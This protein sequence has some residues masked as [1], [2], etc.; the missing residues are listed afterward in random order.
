MAKTLQTGWGTAIRRI[1]QTSPW[2]WLWEFQLEANSTVHTRVRLTA[3]HAQ[4]T[5]NGKTYHPF[6]MHQGT[7]EET[8]EGDLP[9]TRVVLSNVGREFGN[10]FHT[11]AEADGLIG[12]IATSVLV[13]LADLTQFWEYDWEVNDALVGDHSI[14]LSLQMPNFMLR[15][16]PEDRFSPRLCR[17]QF[18]Q[19]TI[20]RP[21]P[22]GYPITAQAA[23]QD[24]PKTLAGCIERGDDEVARGLPRLHPKRFGAFIAIPT[25]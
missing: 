22:C 15:R 12:S 24:C 13:Q 2:V 19:G 23:F 21:S 7:I 25:Q 6:A 10:Y 4:L 5:V 14:E 11:V 9:T 8:A 16:I 18:G 1:N 3:H 20:E 17:F